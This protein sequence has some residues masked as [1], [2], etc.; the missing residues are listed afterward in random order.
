MRLEEPGD[1]TPTTSNRDAGSHRRPEI[2]RFTTVTPV[3]ELDVSFS[4]HP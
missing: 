1:A 4:D 2:D 3:L